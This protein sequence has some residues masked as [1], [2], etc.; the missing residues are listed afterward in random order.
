MAYAPPRAPQRTPRRRERPPKPD[1][2]RRALELLAGCGPDGC[3]EAVLLANGIDVDTMVQIILE[4]LAPRRRSV[5]ALAARCSRL[6]CCELRKWGG[7]RWSRLSHEAKKTNSEGH[8]STI[9]KRSAVINGHKKRVA[10]GNLLG[11]AE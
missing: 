10:G 9:T 11:W 3:N 8:R 1:Q 2:R 4:G 5:R 7:R 6:R